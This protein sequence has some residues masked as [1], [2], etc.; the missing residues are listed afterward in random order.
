MVSICS[1]H[2]EASDPRGDGGGGIQ[3][4]SKVQPLVLLYTIFDRKGPP[5][6]HLLQKLTNGTPVTY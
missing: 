2:Y 5:F 4:D 1:I 6:V 3:Q